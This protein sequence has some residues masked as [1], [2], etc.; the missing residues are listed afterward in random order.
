[1]KAMPAAAAMTAFL[2]AA[3]APAPAQSLQTLK[4]TSQIEAGIGPEQ[5]DRYA[6]PLKRGESA[7]LIVL[8]QGVDLAVDLIAPDGRL[9]TTVDSP[10]GRNGP[11]PLA[12]RAD[13]AGRYEIRVR[14]LSADE[15]SGKYRLTVAELRNAVATRRWLDQRQRVRRSAVQWL[16]ERSVA[17]PAPRDIGPGTPLA[18]FDQLAA[19]VRVVGLGEATHG[20]RELADLRLALTRRLVEK[21]GY[22]LVALEQS[23]VRL[24]ELAPYVSGDA[25]ASVEVRALLERGWIGRRSLAEL[26]D[27]ARGWN[28]AH[29]GDRVA[30]IGVDAQDFTSATERL[31]KFLAE[32]YGPSLAERWTAAKA[33]LLVADE[34]SAMFGNSDVS[35]ATRGFAVEL[36][37]MVQHD[38]P[39]L[40]RRFEPAR[41]E[42]AMETARDLAQF[43][44][45][46]GNGSGAVN[47]NRDWYMAANILRMLDRAGAG[48]RAVYWAHNAHVATTSARYQPTGTVLRSALGCSYAAIGTTFGEGAFIA[49]IPGDPENDIVQSSLPTAEEET[50]DSAMAE[51]GGGGG[52]FATWPCGAGTAAM[53]AWLAQP[54]PMR[55][56]GG[57]FTPGGAPSTATRIFT[58][59]TDFDGLFHVP[60]VS[61]EPIPTDRRPIPPRPR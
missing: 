11:E 43:A 60:R 17:V 35:A 59:A 18:P 38:A 25:G 46:N 28:L 15:P 55:W 29:P 6:L 24:R 33:E 23:A 54:R 58:L 19:R 3:L 12:V 21:H 50:I 8:Q 48:G 42:Q 13:A 39:I 22:R 10:N 52:A 56:V 5:V 14:T 26:V 57:L 45:Y 1:M 2:A 61:A 4:R 30:L 36:Y 37:G 47:H 34:Q 44:D 31:G 51:L 20:S 53:P 40:A 16:R 27:W 32:A 7:E 9:V 41:V 49:Q